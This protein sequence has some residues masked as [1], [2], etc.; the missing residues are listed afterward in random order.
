[1]GE[2]CLSEGEKE[3]DLAPPAEGP[4]LKAERDHSRNM[5]AGRKCADQLV[6]LGVYVEIIS[7]V[8]SLLC[9]LCI[10]VCGSVRDDLGQV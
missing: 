4:A 5:K 8:I 7:G 9:C 3:W 10:N 6:N 1:M 2:L